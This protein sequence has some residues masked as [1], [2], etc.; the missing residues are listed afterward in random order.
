MSRKGG[1]PSIM[2]VFGAGFKK[3]RKHKSKGKKNRAASNGQNNSVNPL[4]EKNGNGVIPSK[5]EKKTERYIS[6]GDDEKFFTGLFHCYKCGK[7][8][9]EGYECIVNGEKRLICKQCREGKIPEK[10]NDKRQYVK[11]IYTPMGNKR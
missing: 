2:R 4:E 7:R 6:L 8:R 5:K 10:T 11:I 3:K 1:I 9:W